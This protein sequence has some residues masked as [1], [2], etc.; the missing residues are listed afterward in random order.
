MSDFLVVRRDGVI[1]AYPV[2]VLDGHDP[3]A[4]L[5]MRKFA[6]IAQQQGRVAQGYYDLSSKMK[7]I[8]GH[9]PPPL[10]HEERMIVE[11]INRPGGQVKLYELSSR[12]H[13]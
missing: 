10:S 11:A 1:P 4:Y 12:P 9:A 2:F 7:S 3:A 8:A 6:D 13:L 5:A